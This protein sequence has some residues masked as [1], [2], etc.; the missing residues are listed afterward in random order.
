MRR[1]F[2]FVMGFILRGLRLFA[3]SAASAGLALRGKLP[4]VFAATLRGGCPAFFPQLRRNR[5]AGGLL[6]KIIRE[7]QRRAEQFAA[8]RC[9]ILR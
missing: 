8:A 2:R 4:E 1:A 7:H 9:A 6:Q 3:R 5:L